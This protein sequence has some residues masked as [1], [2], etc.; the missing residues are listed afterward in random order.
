MPIRYLFVVINLISVSGWDVNSWR[1]KP[2]YQQPTYKNE[3]LLRK[4]EKV[5]TEKPPLVL[6]NEIDNL[7]Q[8]LV[9]VEQ[10]KRFIFMGGDCAETFR[11]H[12]S[13]NIINNYQL[14]IL[15]TILLMT[16]TGMKITKIA[17]AAG[18]F[19]KPR[20][21]D[22][23]IINGKQ[24]L[25]Y[26]GDMINYEDVDKREPDPIL[27]L[28]AYSQCTETLNLI[29]ALTHSHKFS[30]IDVNTWKG[31]IFSDIYKTKQMKELFNKVSLSINV[32]SSTELENSVNINNAQVYT[33]HEGLL[34]NY[35]Q[36]LT[37]RDRFSNNY[38]DCSSH[39]VWIGERTR[40]I[41]CG[42]VE[43][44]RGVSNP[45]GIKIS[46]KI[47]PKELVNLI[48]N[49]NPNNE[50]GKICVISRMGAHIKEHLPILIDAVQDEQLRVVWICDPMHGNGK[51]VN[52]T[53]TRFLKDIISEVESFFEIHH[54]KGTI[55]G[56]IHLEM[57]GSDVTECVGG[58]YIKNYNKFLEKNYLS[59][60]DPRLNFFQTIE[61]I[62]YVS[63]LIV[64]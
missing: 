18:Q 56:G 16:E 43:F 17:R 62:E 58:K 12:S 24:Y 1:C 22:Y 3:K 46:H 34:L 51:V 54:E 59:S 35:E 31:D 2:V 41:D 52:E 7:K 26:K 42:H 29:R 6:S 44:F 64:K 11:E 13:K 37:R 25:A 4:V 30:N 10:G 53:K 57:T 14:F 28:K 39:F 55:P 40:Q 23:E 9:E 20:S 38:Y 45:I 15:S 5:L 36:A 27:M 63:K 47:E 50:P 33:G 49:L 21:N 61:L 60:C 32:L 8:E 48:K 19:S